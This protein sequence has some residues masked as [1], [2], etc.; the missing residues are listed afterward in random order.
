MMRHLKSR[1]GQ[2]LVEMAL[3]LPVLLILVMGVISYGLYINAVDTVQQSVRL[4]VRAASIGDTMGCP[5]N[6][7]VIQLAAGQN[8]TVYGVVDD[9]ITTNQWLASEHTATPITFAAVVGNQ[10]TATQNTVMVTV[11]LAYHP[12]VPLPGLL[13]ATVEIAQTYE[14]LVQNNQPANATTTTEPTGSPYAETTQWTTP[15]PPSTNVNYLVQPNG[16]P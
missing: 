16:C 13:P 9:Q 3:V 11:A 6:S 15:P 7:A 1:S 4:A 2:A 5:G 8:P 10:S 12:V 14:M